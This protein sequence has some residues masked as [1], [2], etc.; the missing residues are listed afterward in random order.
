MESRIKIQNRNIYVILLVLAIA[1]I[2]YSIG[3]YWG[4]TSVFEPDESKLVEPLREMVETKTLVH[5]TWAY[6]A[7]ASSKVLALILIFVSEFYHLEPIQYYHIN[8]SFYAILGTGIVYLTWAIVRKIKSERFSL[9]LAA[10]MAIC[11]IWV[12]YSKEVTGDIP[13]LFFSLLVL[14]MTQ[15]YVKSSMNRYLV[16]MSLFAACST[17]EKW[18]GA[19]TCLFIAISVIL[20]Y[21][22]NLRKI[23]EA[24]IVASSAYFTSIVLL[25]PNIIVDFR[26]L[27]SGIEFTYVYDGMIENP[28]LLSYPEYFFS[29]LG[30]VSVIIIGIG[31]YNVIFKTDEITDINYQIVYLFSPICLFAFWFIMVRVT[32]ERWGCGVYWGLLLL[33]LD[34]ISFLIQSK[35]KNARIAG[36]IAVALIL[37]CFLS[38][39]ILFNLIATHTYN[40][41]RIVGEHVLSSLGANDSNTLSDYYTPLAPGGIRASGDSLPIEFQDYK[42]KFAY[43]KNGKPYI[44]RPD[45]KYVII[46]GYF[47]NGK[48]INGYAVV[49]KYGKCVAE[50][51]SKNT[52]LCIFVEQTT[53]GKWHMVEFDNIRANI[54]NIKLILHN[55]VIG[56]E[57]SVYDVS[58]FTYSE[59]YE[60]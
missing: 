13:A 33:T 1:L 10:L 22:K 8:R 38:E 35:R 2:N 42:N 27:V 32:F 6:P 53:D 43:E 17:L 56:P 50:V 4:E 45:T 51:K 49:K 29:H 26:R 28:P 57:F 48:D 31:I 37:A 15:Y 34:G 14:L 12:R 3:F 40:D 46:G 41:G 23:V 20:L 5:D 21:K 44:V 16:L 59:Q 18:H 9:A 55:E 25:A 30:I 11:P 54:N 39:S 47:P 36:M 24:G 19:W 58:D 60:G 7:Q 52:R